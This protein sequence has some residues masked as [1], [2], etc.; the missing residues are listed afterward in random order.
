MLEFLDLPANECFYESSLEQV[1]IDPAT[2]TSILVLRD[3]DQFCGRMNMQ[4]ID[5]E[6]PELGIDIL[7]EYQNQGHGPVAITAFAN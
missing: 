5:E 7:K 1:L 2:L 4:K 6:V 3:D